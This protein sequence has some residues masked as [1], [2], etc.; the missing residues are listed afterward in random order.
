MEAE[1]GAL[2]LKRLIDRRSADAEVAKLDIFIRVR[3]ATV[4]EAVVKGL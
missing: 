1:V 2:E 4:C 3:I